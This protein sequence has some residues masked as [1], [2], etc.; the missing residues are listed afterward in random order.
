MI[1]LAAQFDSGVGLLWPDLGPPHS[2]FEFYIVDY[3]EPTHYVDIGNVLPEK[4]CQK[5]Q[6]GGGGTKEKEDTL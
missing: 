3:S 6:G 2:G 1:A 4:V 5:R